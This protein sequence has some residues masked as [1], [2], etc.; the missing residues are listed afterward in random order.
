MAQLGIEPPDNTNGSQSFLGSSALSPKNQTSQD[1]DFEGW[2]TEEDDR[3]KTGIQG[4]PLVQTEYDDRPQYTM[5]LASWLAFKGTFDVMQCLARLRFKLMSYFLK[6][7]KT[8][9]REDYSINAEDQVSIEFNNV[10][11]FM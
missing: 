8:P 9:H 6:V 3:S 2:R 11:F 1:N 10:L 5:E 4:T 7:L